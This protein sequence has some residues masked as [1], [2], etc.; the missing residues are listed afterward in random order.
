MNTL[1]SHDNL[2]LLKRLLAF[3]DVKHESSLEI[4]ALLDCWRWGR[5]PIYFY[6]GIS[7]SCLLVL[8]MNG[9]LIN[10][11]GVLLGEDRV[12]V[13]GAQRL[14]RPLQPYSGG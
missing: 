2:H 11:K 12:L 4:D 13:Q 7:G 5:R 1:L 6:N 8:F 9:I 10:G 14:L 3:W